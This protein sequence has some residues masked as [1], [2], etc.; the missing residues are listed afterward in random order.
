MKRYLSI[1]EALI[2]YYLKYH[3]AASSSAQTLPQQRKVIK[4]HEVSRHCEFCSSRQTVCVIVCA[5]HQ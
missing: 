4:S 1:A 5:I 3:S 2:V